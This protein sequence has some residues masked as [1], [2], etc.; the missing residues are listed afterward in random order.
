MIKH[1][2]LYKEVARAKLNIAKSMVCRRW[3]ICQEW[4]QDG[5]RRDTGV[6]FSSELRGKEVWQ[7]TTVRVKQKLGLWSEQKLNLE[8]K[9]RL[10]SHDLAHDSTYRIAVP[11]NMEYSLCN[12]EEHVCVYFWGSQQE[13]LAWDILY[14]QNKYGGGD[15]PDV[16]LF[17]VAKYLSLYCN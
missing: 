14:R 13:R 2:Q 12:A 11:P 4:G 7:K 10:K 9:V 5:K 3:G 8:G 6:Y 1:S 16:F 15:F 17:I